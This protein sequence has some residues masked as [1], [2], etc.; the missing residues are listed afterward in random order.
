MSIGSAIFLWGFWVLQ[1]VEVCFCENL[2]GKKGWC[3]CL[4]FVDGVEEGG[5]GGVEGKRRAGDCGVLTNAWRE[6]AWAGGFG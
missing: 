3:C 1:F 4:W 2:I 6:G 5:F